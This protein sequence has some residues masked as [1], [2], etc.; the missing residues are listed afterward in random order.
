MTQKLSILIHLIRTN[1]GNKRLLK[2]KKDQT[3][4]NDTWFHSV[5][6]YVIQQINVISK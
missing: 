5:H 6:I 4:N 2:K 1:S 3:E